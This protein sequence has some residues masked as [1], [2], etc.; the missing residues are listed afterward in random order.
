M[1]KEWV[2]LL[3]VLLLSA[4]ALGQQAARPAVPAPEL[5]PVPANEYVQRVVQHELNAR[6]DYAMMYRDWRQ[7]PEGSKTKEMIETKAGIVARLIAIND[8]PLTPEQRQADDA[9]LQNL[10]SNPNL[11]KQKQKEQQQD[12]DRVKR[13]FRELPKAFLFQYVGID[14]GKHG[15]EVVHLSF[16]PNPNYQAP[17]REM[18]V[19]KGMGGNLWVDKSS[20]RL[21]KIEATLFRDVTFGWGIL[22]HL[23]K[24]GHFIVEQAKVAPD[25]WDATD[26]NIQFTGKALLFKTINLRQI[27]K[28]S[29][30]RRVPDGLTLAQGIEILKKSENQVA[31]N[32]S[33]GK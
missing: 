9:R 31:E 25:R 29:D 22:G 33:G 30:F 2:K 32:T 24:G 18:S 15:N 8:R 11:Q 1:L 13:M 7:T 16:Q 20:E 17:S 4:A 21:T 23:D 3:P 26:M 6:E 14:S 5:P 12:D 10:L 27:E 28:I 19:Y